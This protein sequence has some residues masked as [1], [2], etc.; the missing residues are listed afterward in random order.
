M[1]KKTIWLAESALTY[2]ELALTQ[3]TRKAEGSGEYD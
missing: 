3:V 1:H 2:K